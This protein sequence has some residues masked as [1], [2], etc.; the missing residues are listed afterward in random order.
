MPIKPR[1][2]PM[3]VNTTLTDTEGFVWDIQSNSNLNPELGITN[4][5]SDAF[6]GG[7]RLR[8]NG[9]A[10]NP[11]NASVDGREVNTQPVVIGG[12]VVQRSILV[13]DA[14]V[15]ATG[16]ARFLDSFT[17][18]TGAEVTIT[19]ETGTNSGADGNLQF[20][21][22][23]SL[24]TV[25]DNFDV[26]F[27]TSD[28]AIDG[29][30]D[31]RVMIAYGTVNSLNSLPAD[32]TV[33]GDEITITHR[34]TLRPGETRS[35]LQFATQSDTNTEAA[36]DLDDFTT[37]A[38]GLLGLDAP[39]GLSREEMLSIVNYTK[40]DQIVDPLDLRDSEGNLWSIGR[41]GTISSADGALNDFSLPSFSENFATFAGAARNEAENSVTVTNTDGTGTL[42]GSVT[43]EYTALEGLGVIR[44][45]VT[46][47]NTAGS[48]VLFAGFSELAGGPNGSQLVAQVLGGFN[49]QVTGVVIDDSISGSG[50]SVP[51]ASVVWGAINA[52]DA[53]SL[54]ADT[55]LNSHGNV[56]LAGGQVH[57]FVHF[58]AV[59]D[60]GIAALADLIR[61]NNPGPELLAYM[62][63]A[64]VAAL[65]NFDIAEF[66]GRLQEVLGADGVDDEITGHIWG[67]SI[68]SGSGDDVIAALA[69]DDIVRGGIG[70]DEIDG[71]DGADSLFGGTDVD[72]LIGGTGNDQMFGEDGDDLLLGQAG[73]DL[74]Y[75]GE[76]ND[77][78]YGGGGADH[79]DG[80]F[81]LD[82]LWGNIG[83]DTVFGGGSADDLLGGIGIDSLVGGTGTD[84]LFGGGG[85]DTLYGDTENDV[86]NGGTGTDSLFGGANDDVLNGDTGN[87]TLNGDA[88][89]DGLF[90]GDDADVLS[91]GTENDTLGGGTGDDTLN[92]DDGNDSLEGGDNA[93]SLVGGSND[94]QLFGGNGADRLF[95]G[96]GNDSLTGGLATDTGTNRLFGGQG[97]DSYFITSTRDQV[98]E[99][100][101]GTGTDAVF[102]DISY[103]LGADVENLTLTGIA[104]LN[105]TGNALANRING[106]SGDNILDGGAGADT[107]EGGLF[108]D[109]YIVDN[110]LDVVNEAA[111]FAQG[112]DTVRSTVTYTLSD[113]VENLEFQGSA[114]ISGTGNDQANV[115]TGNGQSNILNGGL[116]S[117]TLTGGSGPDAFV[118]STALGATNIDHITD[119][120]RAADKIHLDD[121]I[122][123]AFTP[124][125]VGGGRFINGTV[126]LQTDD[127]LLYDLATGT[128]RYD[129]DG[130][131]LWASSV[132]IAVFDDLV[133]LSA[134][135]F[136][137]I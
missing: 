89:N 130:S 12:I 113:N 76:E 94:D 79:V 3:P 45:L 106:N 97:S 9:V 24:D 20:P 85:N 30:G 111:G 73:N 49:N 128:L 132:V 8:V 86:L 55:L 19:V 32:A 99:V 40:F 134:G 93:D 135:N 110:A 18:T 125:N 104:P 10:V 33:V 108:N 29:S 136:L 70:D 28:G 26:G 98:T 63:A 119:F 4:G 90:G 2:V 50:G 71:G 68:V 61:F 127:Q 78:M 5:T 62:S 69:S 102:S 131:G 41:N 107:M 52:G 34:I 59:N 35:L 43:N 100:A 25:L 66:Q 84:E 64:E 56:M 23:R 116:G 14:Q 91:G 31:P 126:A 81:G 57:T 120:G 53:F 16:F 22:T 67:D 137:I 1:D 109:I 129:A 39:T 96:G 6:D 133:P 83:D 15:S 82:T 87:D 58:L 114:A 75:G 17:N 112:T 42:P 95:G 74:L 77:R 101:G 21:I 115:I 48:N 103:T 36:G 13:S 122:F 118:F 65:R 7:M 117:D 38:V 92:G 37:D 51:A 123:T 121:A 27:T 60:T 105:G 44:L 54:A 80:S 72:N 47:D 124:G 88:G 46:F 11:Q